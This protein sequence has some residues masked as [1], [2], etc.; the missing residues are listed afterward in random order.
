MNHCV[1]DFQVGDDFV[2]TAASAS[3]SHGNNGLTKTKKAAM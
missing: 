1:P 3:G 2:I